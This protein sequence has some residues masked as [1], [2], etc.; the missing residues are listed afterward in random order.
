V[1][2]FLFFLFYIFLYSYYCCTRGTLWHLQKL[3]Q[4][5]IVEFTPLC[6]S[7]LP[8]ILPFLEQFHHASFSH[9]HTWVHNISIIS[10]PLPLVPTPQAVLDFSLLWQHT[11]EKQLKGRSIYFTSQCQTRAA[12]IMTARKQRKRMS[13]LLGFLLIPL[14]FQ[15]RVNDATLS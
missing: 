13:L 7:P 9:F 11:S 2:N 10:S 4:C 12:H 3:L 1:V 8:S 15:N 6:H 5:I 14:L